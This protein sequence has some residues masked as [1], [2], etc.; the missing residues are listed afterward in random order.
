M[1]AYALEL[2]QNLTKTNMAATTV[3]DAS[4]RQ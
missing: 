3:E 4:V 1:L 2:N